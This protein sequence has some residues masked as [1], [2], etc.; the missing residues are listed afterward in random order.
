MPQQQMYSRVPIPMPSE[1]LEEEPVYVNAKQYHR[2]MMRRQA[3][4]K[5][6]QSNQLPRQRKVSRYARYADPNKLASLTIFSQAFLHQSR[7]EHAMRRKRG[8]GGRFLTKEEVAVMR[9]EE[10]DRVAALGVGADTWNPTGSEEIGGP[11]G[12]D[13][14]SSSSSSTTPLAPS[15]PPAA[16]RLRAPPS[17]A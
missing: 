8:P 10:A 14:S 6:E 1:M 12:N 7:H 13:S 16:A 4:Q 5:L 2:I 11:F 15:A 3:R 17:F 9:K